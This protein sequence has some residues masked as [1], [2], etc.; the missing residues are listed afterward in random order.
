MLG[1]VAQVLGDLAQLLGRS[2]EARA[3]YERAARVAQRWGARHW[4]DRALDRLAT[5]TRDRPIDVAAG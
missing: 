5:V 4:V 2:D 1:P 3:Q